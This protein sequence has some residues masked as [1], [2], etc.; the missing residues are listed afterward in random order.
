M[1][2]LTN[3]TIAV[4]SAVDRDPAI[5]VRTDR[6]HDRLVITVQDNGVGISEKNLGFRVNGT[7]FHDQRRGSGNGP[8]FEYLA[9]RLF[10]TMVDAWR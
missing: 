9:T 1:N 3:A 6:N 5:A 2:L 10:G 4:R 8:G 7:F